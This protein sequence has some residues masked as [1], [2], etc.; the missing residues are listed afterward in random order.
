MRGCAR[1]EKSRATPPATL[2]AALAIGLTTGLALLAIGLAACARP[3]EGGHFEIER[4]NARWAN[5]VLEGDCR[6]AL[7]LS[8]EA[9][10]ALRHGVPLTI[11]LELIL[12]SS[13]DQTRVGAETRRFEIRYLPLSEHYR[14]AGLGQGHSGTFPRLRHALAEL[15]RIDFS[16]VTGA[17][18]AGDYE[19]LARSRLDHHSMPPPMRLP[20]LFDAGWN[21]AST[22]S[23]W[24][25]TVDA[26]G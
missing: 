20:A 9:R 18:P 13:T 6:L 14:V 25:L 4:I 15:S 22:W 2:R 11:E 7:Q 16:I 24:P 23:A 12:R 26:D 19:L 1:P 3:A 21:H 5:G 17:L 8:S 10:N